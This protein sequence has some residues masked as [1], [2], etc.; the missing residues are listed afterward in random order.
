MEDQLKGAG[1]AQKIFIRS[2]AKF[3]DCHV[4]VYAGDKIFNCGEPGHPLK[5]QFFVHDEQFFSRA[6]FGGDIG[7]GESYMDGDWSSPDLVA[8]IRAAVR[9][10]EQLDSGNRLVSAL[11]RRFDRMKHRRNDNTETGSRKNISYH[12]DLGN[13]FYKLFLDET[14]A[15]SCAWFNSVTDTLR[16]AQRNKF[17]RICRKLDLKPSDH[18]LEIGTGWGGF[19][20]YAAENYGCRVTTT[21]ISQQQYDYSRRLFDSHPDGGRINLLLEDYRNLRGRFDKLVSIEMFEAVGHRHY[22]EYFGACDRLLAPDGLMLIQAITMNER[23]FKTYLRESDW[24]KRYIFPG[25]ELASISEVLKSAGRVGTLQLAHMEDMGEHY[26]QTLHA[27]R[28]RFMARL[29]EVRALGFDR[30]FERMWEYYLAYCEGGFLEHYIGDAQLLL[31]K[32]RTIL[33]VLNHWSSD[34]MGAD[35]QAISAD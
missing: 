2:I 30:R 21:T 26:A 25:A 27:W 14:M 4:Q 20:I 13:D 1:F 22:D 19:A 5:A 7:I 23:H 18:L 12:Y 34:A 24:I 9:N 28:D 11:A 15:Y 32:P 31:A 8:V 33:A 6:V 17:E 3:R 35:E 10:M 29:P 16:A